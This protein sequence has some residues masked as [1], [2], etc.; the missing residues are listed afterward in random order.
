[1]E[2]VE[3]PHNLHL[4]ALEPPMFCTTVLCVSASV[5]GFRCLALKNRPSTMLVP[6]IVR[7]WL[8]RHPQDRGIFAIDQQVSRLARPPES[9]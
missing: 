2:V 3:Y 7:S 8:W 9:T 1:M 6:Q 5:A 4:Y